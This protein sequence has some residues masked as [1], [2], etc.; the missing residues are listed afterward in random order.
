MAWYDFLVDAGSKALEKT[1][2]TDVASNVGSAL[3]ARDAAKSSAAA[4]LAAGQ[5]AAA[6]AEFKPY[7][8]TTGFGTSFFDKDK[9]TA[10]YEMDPALKAF[11]DTFYKGAGEFLGQVTSDPM[12]AARRYQATQMG[13]LTDPRL[14]EDQALRAQQLQSGRIGLGL[15][16]VSQGAG[17]GTG[18]VNPEQYQRDLARARIDAE[19][20]ANSYNMGQ[21]DIDRS[22]SRGQGLLSS[23]TGIE[24]LA[25][26][27]LTLGSDIGNRAAVAGAQ[28][29]ANLLAG[30]QAAAQANLASGLGTAG[31]FK[32]IGMAVGGMRFNPK[33]GGYDP[34]A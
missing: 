7:S 16:G 26:K 25:M 23:A 30:G 15:S 13:L 14:A 8:I 4:N 19:I 28:A 29:G 18:V 21:A 3:I 10:G 6:A 2:W 11:Q 27:P 17:A 12:E 9:Q 22:I 32:N 20:A 33:T 5:Q 24:E 31:M 34:V 1:S